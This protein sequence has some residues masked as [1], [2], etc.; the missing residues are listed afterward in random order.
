MFSFILLAALFHSLREG[1]SFISLPGWQTTTC[2][3]VR[4][5]IV[6]HL[7]SLC[8]LVCWPSRQFII[9]ESLLS[10]FVCLRPLA[11]R[12]CQV[13]KAKHEDPVEWKCFESSWIFWSSLLF[14][15]RRGIVRFPTLFLLP[16]ILVQSMINYAIKTIWS[17]INPCCFLIY[18]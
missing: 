1:Y 5:S 3:D 11:Y 13:S 15:Q 4:R 14:M 6:S 16:S 9:I 10:K 2:I 12:R 17:I 7:Q 8:R 18:S